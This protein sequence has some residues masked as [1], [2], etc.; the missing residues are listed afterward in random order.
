MTAQAQQLAPARP[1][2]VARNNRLA[3]ASLVLS[4]LWLFGLGSLLG[5][6]L[7]H[8][9]LRQIEASGELGRGLAIGGLVLGYLALA[10]L[11]LGLVAELS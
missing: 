11:A 6:V 5:V 8:I 10:V 7:G 9:A 2:P 1:Q 4:A 3:V